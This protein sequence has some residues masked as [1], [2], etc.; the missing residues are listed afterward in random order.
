VGIYTRQSVCQPIRA[1]E[2]L[3]GVLCPPGS[4]TSYRELPDEEAIGGYPSY[5][6]LLDL[7]VDPAALDAEGRCVVVEFPAFV[8]FGVYC[9]A[10]SSGTDQGIA[11]R[12]AFW[13]ALDIRIRNLDRMGKRVIL[14]G[15]LNNAK[16][17]L[18]VAGAE[19][20]KRKEGVSHAEYVSTPNRR[21]L[22]QLLED[23]EV[24]GSRD[25]G[26]EKP[27]LHDACRAFHPERQGMYTHW[28]T[29]KNTRPGNFGSRI[30]YVLTSI[31]MKSWIKD[32]NIQEGLLVRHTLHCSGNC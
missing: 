16:C 32:S 28:D 27:V 23:G 21:I 19:E 11:F 3:L 14:A 8:L 31:S 10:N 12:H 1:E 9:P 22:N 2:G 24:F 18:D 4:S 25:E 26:R 13:N 30:D 7:G 5:S 17:E 29:K 20:D 6:E 15:D